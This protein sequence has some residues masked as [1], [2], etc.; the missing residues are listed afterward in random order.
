MRILLL[1]DEYSLR[2][3]V[4][5]FLEDIGFK[6]DSFENSDDAMDALFEKN[7]DL[8]LLDVKVPGMNGFEFLK[9]LREHNIEIPAIFITSMTHVNDLARG[10]ECGCCDYIKKPFDLKEL[11]IRV[12]NALKRECFKANKDE[13]TLPDGYIYDTKKFILKKDNIEVPL[14]KTEKRILEVLIKHRGNVVTMEQFQEEVWGEYKDLANVRVQ[15]NKLRKKV[16]KDLIK[17]IHGLG[18]KIDI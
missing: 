3:S 9:T 7:Y 10:F 14:T 11:Q 5:E 2:I 6:V 13:I 8:M 4:E 12:E 15:I 16:S 18:Y 1:E 17:N